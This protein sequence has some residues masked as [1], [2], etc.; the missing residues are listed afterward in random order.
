MQV[1]RGTSQAD[2][3]VQLSDGMKTVKLNRVLYVL[4]VGQKFVSAPVVCNDG[5]TVLFTKRGCIVK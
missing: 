2:S 4:K 3:K 1:H 5:Q